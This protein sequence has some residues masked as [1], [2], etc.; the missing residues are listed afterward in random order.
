[1][2]TPLLC[3]WVASASAQTRPEVGLVLNPLVSVDAADDR[4]SEDGIESWIWLRASVRQPG[5]SG[6]FLSIEGEHQARLGA[7]LEATW[8]LR[9]GESGWTGPAGPLHLRAGNLIERWGKLDMLSVVDVLN[10]KDLRAGPLTAIES[11]RVPVPMARLQHKLGPLRTELVLMPFAVADR[12]DLIGGDWALIRP[13]MIQRFTHEATTWE[14]G[15]A[16]LIADGIQSLD[17]GLQQ[18]AP[19][20]L[21]GM[22]RSVSTAGQPEATLLT[23]EAALRLQLEGTGIDGALMIGA[24]RTRTPATRLAPELQAI[25][26]AGQWPPLDQVGEISAAMGEPLST[27]WPRTWFAGAEASTM[28]GPVGLRAEAG[29]WSR[30]VVQ[31]PW[32]GSAVSPKLSGGLG[33]DWMHSTTLMLSLESRYTRILTP[34]E[35]LVMMREEQLEL[36]GMV[37]WTTLQDRLTLLGAA[38]L[39]PQH[40]E[41]L[42]R[43]EVR[44]RASDTLQLGL[45]AVWLGGSAATPDTLQEAM[46]YEAGPMAYF[47]ENDCLFV[48]LQWIQ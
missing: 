24:L 7:D 2:L 42:A 29:G 18:M 21:R 37:R 36:G 10:P 19:S 1:M 41:Y 8:D 16:P 23:G 38:M 32:L 3:A 11:T 28:V 6:W 30:A 14:G 4:P 47:S 22:T 26:E 13:G 20:T 15:S 43:P 34:P 48:Q 45:G 40:G 17:D 33:L 5:A 12:V 35:A 25:L 31:T 27:S 39:E 44:Y 9:A 46:V